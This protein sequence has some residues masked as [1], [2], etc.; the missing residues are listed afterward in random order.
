MD[1]NGYSDSILITQAG[2]CYLCG[3]RGDTARHEVFYGPLRKTSKRMGLWVNLCPACHR[4]V[5]REAELS[6]ML[7]KQAELTYFEKG[8]T[9]SGWMDHKSGIGRNFL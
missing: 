3:L 5:H 4:K 1:R 9:W 6:V 8:G 2:I 7:K